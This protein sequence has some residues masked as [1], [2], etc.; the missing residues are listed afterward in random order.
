M[1]VTE[2]P[3]PWRTDGVAFDVPKLISGLE[4][5][6]P[7]SAR[8]DLLTALKHARA[9]ADHD[10]WD[11]PAHVLYAQAVL[12][13]AVEWA[14]PAVEKWA[15]AWLAATESPQLR[16]R[17]SSRSRDGRTRRDGLAPSPVGALATGQGQVI[18]GCQSGYVASWTDEAGLS[19]L[20]VSS[21]D[22]VWAVAARGDRVFAAGAHGHFV[23]S[24][25]EWALPSLR[26]S[27][28]AVV[29]AAAISPEG[30][31]AC[32]DLSGGTFICPAG[33]GWTSLRRLQADSR[34]LALCFD[35]DSALWA[36]WKDSRVTKAMPSADGCWDWRHEFELQ[37]GQPLA[38]AFDQGGRQFAL[39]LPDGEV[40]V[41][42]LSDMRPRRG[43]A[44]PEAPHREVRALTWSPGGLLALSGK[45]FLLVGEP[46]KPPEQI[47]GEG[48]G[49][50]AAFLDD[51]HLVTAQRTDIVDWA[52]RE[53]GSDVPDPYVR[54][55]VT[56]V[57]VDPR[58]PSYSM[59]GTQR[60]RVLRYDSRGSG[61]LM[62]ADPDD[63]S[64]IGP[65]T[66]SAAGPRIRSSI[67]QFARLGDDWLIAAHTG[68]Y[69]L[70]PSGTLTRLRP[71]PLDEGSY[72]CW[73]VNAVGDDGAFAW[74]KQ[75]RA[76]SGGPP[77]TFSATVRDIC[78][79]TDG[80]LAAIDADGL[81]LVRDG[82]GDEWSPPA[83]PR[84][85]GPYR[86]GWR[87]L[88]ADGKSVT[89]WNPSPRRRR[90]RPIE[91]EAVSLSR[92]GEQTRLGRLP[93]DA[94]AVLPFDRHRF[95]VACPE[96]GIALV[97]AE[98]DSSE[99]GIVGVS[100]RAQAIAVGGHRI[101]AAAGKR[102]A[103]YDLLEPADEGEH[104]VIPLQVVLTGRTCRV[105]LPGS[106][107]IELP[108]DDIE[109]LRGTEAGL[110]SGAL[111]I[112]D[113][114]AM[115]AGEA[116]QFAARLLA[117]GTA[118]ASR[119]QSALVATAGRIGDQI[120]HNG[121]NLAVDR[122]RGDDPGRAVRLAWHCDEET[123]DI[124]WELVHPSESPLG[125]FDDPPV[126]SVRSVSPR[127]GSVRA[128]DEQAVTPMT[129]HRMLVIRGR[130]FELATS[131]DVFTQTSRRTRLSNLT[132]LRPQPLVI[133]NET[134]LDVALREPMDIL[135]VWA[136]CGPTRA[137]FSDDAWF[138]TTV[139]AR[140]LAQRV[141][142]LAVIVGCRSGALGRAL[143]ERGVE[144]VVAMRVE[145]YS[146][147]I[148]SLVTDLISRALDGIP[149]DEAFADALRSYVLTGQPGA[150]AVPMLYL[151]AGSTGKLFG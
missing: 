73:T 121:L 40:S 62:S 56:A 32:G 8:H 15:V 120:W 78:C 135:Q 105:T 83:P 63:R 146:R 29:G 97:T 103:G 96:R 39:C 53:A 94:T 149:I 49:G 3:L 132:M 13:I 131:D 150:A 41:I 143:A 57:A 43:W 18:L 81:I 134:D 23:T 72:L 20:G 47:R 147:T 27:A 137:K 74:R 34:V 22:A 93:A 52:V 85:G 70:T 48:A 33:E 117:T 61:M 45:E 139:L 9:R 51:D 17:W 144:A 142:R 91:G 28:N 130:D 24:P 11:S 77:L 102:V 80:S 138:E 90:G 99:S 92:F 35:E 95:L 5:Y 2:L 136:H 110:A 60:G 76:V 36:V 115:S 108:G 26:E 100:T 151:A 1:P 6:P 141:S 109:A 42:G 104:S 133:R 86:S 31:V 71:T 64:P 87:L 46:G 123:D 107:V 89:V 50:L 65:D 127:A 10:P 124:P 25:Q 84:A 58:E 75:V 68:A 55:A 38:V 30:H 125:W 88:T 119:H 4:G 19:P 79:G 129:R 82:A 67:H 106:S 140:R 114:E 59:A 54:D 111:D 98:R 101:V 128:G 12:E 118:L 145:V 44:R 69:R 7:G 148:Q 14:M 113:A 122:A 112:C 66:R 126:T 116:R 21:E 37:L 16:L